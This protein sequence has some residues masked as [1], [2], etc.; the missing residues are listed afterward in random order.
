MVYK[1]APGQ[2][3]ITL[4]YDRGVMIT[5]G[6][7]TS[8][9]IIAEVVNG[10]G[11]ADATGFGAEHVFDRDDYKSVAGR[12][13]QDLGS[14]FRLGGFAYYG[15][16]DE[17][18]GTVDETNDVMYW[19]PDASIN[20]QDYVELSVQYLRRTDSNPSY[21]PGYDMDDITTDGIMA[22]LVILPNK[23]LSRHYAVLMYNSVETDYQ[24]YRDAAVAIPDYSYETAALH[25]G[26]LYTRNIR[27]FVEYLY[28]FDLE[29]H[30]G[31]AGFSFAF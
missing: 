8:T 12:I 23:D 17:P 25:L 22:E 18:S 29:D 6:L 19:G 5:L 21:A 14:M 20:Y 28:N 3:S 26:H 11:L 1:Y 24:P 7:P 27:F 16:E 2:S 4:G 9:D 31:G 10:N 30:F 13:S 15:Q